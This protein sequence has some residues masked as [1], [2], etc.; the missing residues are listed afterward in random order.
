MGGNIKI[1]HHKNANTIV[2][3]FIIP[4]LKSFDAILGNDSLKKLGAVIDVRNKTMTLRN[5]LIVP[6]IEK[7]FQAVNTIIPRMEHLTNNQKKELI[8]LVKKYANLF[9]DP[10]YTLTYTTNVRAEI[11]TNCDTPVYTKFYQYP[12]TLKDEV[13]RQF[14]ELLDNDIIWI[15]QSPYNSLSKEKKKKFTIENSTV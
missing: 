12:M 15:S 4:S 9:A 2:S 11:R 6:I 10:N 1:T 14:K 7:Y 5:K 13:D 3:F 8:H